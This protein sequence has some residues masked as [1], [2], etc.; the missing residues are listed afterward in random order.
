MKN[1]LVT[2]LL[3][4]IVGFIIV[5]VQLFTREI[6]L[7]GVRNIDFDLIYSFTN[8]KNSPDTADI[9]KSL[10]TLV[11]NSNL[12]FPVA[13]LTKDSCIDNSQTNHKD[14]I[15]KRI[16]SLSSFS[17]YLNKQDI[18]KIDGKNYVNHSDIYF[19][20]KKFKTQDAY[21]IAHAGKYYLSP[22]YKIVKFFYFLNSDLRAY[23]STQ[24]GRSDLYKESRDMF[25][26]ILLLSLY[27]S[28][29]YL[30]RV[31][32]NFLRYKKLIGQKRAQ[33]KEWD[34]ALEQQKQ[35]RESLLKKE[36]EILQ[37]EELLQELQSKSKY[38]S[39]LQDEI[40]T[41]KSS[42]KSTQER[43]NNSIETIS[44]LEKKEENLIKT[45]MQQSKKLSH[46]D[47]NSINEENYKELSLI[48]K[49]WRVEP[50][51]IERSEIESSVATNE[52]RTPFTMTQAFISFDG[53][54]LSR[55]RK[56]GYQKKESEDLF[57]AINFLQEKRVLEP[58]EKGLFHKIRIS[59]NDWFHHAK[60]PNEII[61]KKLLGLLQSS[62][63]KPPL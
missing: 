51:W 39:K 3:T 37:K 36:D 21:L 23:I 24:K 4:F 1:I 9:Q 63:Q 30:K 26:T 13:V 56:H 47:N 12:L 35:I 6:T 31:K 59:R 28:Y 22:D 42:T 19:M 15:C 46:K 43:L 32:L 58:G 41:L 2:V 52:K 45:I 14:S 34:S 33:K 27:L 55:A 8:T 53:Y 62:Q 57:G 48:K 40:N 20:F 25:F 38:D 5:I 50:K 16:T 61:I 29:L 11:H 18:L 10:N 17:S 60:Y 49:L 7:D 54:I 44:V